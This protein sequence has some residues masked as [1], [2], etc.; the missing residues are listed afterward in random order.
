MSKNNT[1]L[2]EPSKR[3]TL[4][5]IYFMNQNKKKIIQKL[6]VVLRNKLKTLFNHRIPENR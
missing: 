2:L 4:I 1:Y 6:F 5:P 3:E